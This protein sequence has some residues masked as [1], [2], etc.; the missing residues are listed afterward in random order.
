[1]ENFHT[2]INDVIGSL[3][4]MSCICP[5]A[6]HEQMLISHFVCIKSHA[7]SVVREE[8]EIFLFFDS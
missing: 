2:T 5:S 8:Q 4:M 3:L 7:L 6:R 1:M